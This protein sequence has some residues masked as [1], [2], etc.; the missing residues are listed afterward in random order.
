M[1]DGLECTHT[2]ICDY[3]CAYKQMLYTC[4]YKTLAYKNIVNC[5][6]KLFKLQ[7]C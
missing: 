6:V 3:M 7:D 5:L 1:L 2:H 4:F